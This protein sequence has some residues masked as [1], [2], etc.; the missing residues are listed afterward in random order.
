[1]KKLL[2]LLTAIAAWAA[3]A[4]TNAPRTYFEVYK[5]TIDTPLVRGMSKAGVLTGQAAYPVELRIE[6][7][8]IQST[9]NTVYAVA[10]RTHLPH[11]VLQVD[12]IDYDELAG[13]IRGLQFVSQSGHSV[14]P[15]DDF[16][17]VYR[18][19]SGLSVAKISNGN[20]VIINI[21][22]GDANGTRNQIA[23]YV[24]DQLQSLLTGAKSA[25]DSL[26][27]TGQ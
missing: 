5:S 17:V 15:M 23:P 26:A 13:L 25:I 1:M 19:R 18:V 20:N 12:Y 27:A 4:Q 21:K 8:N 10:L 22:C 16:E 9:T 3:Q 2:I 24:L 11:G 7:L 14:V 6:R